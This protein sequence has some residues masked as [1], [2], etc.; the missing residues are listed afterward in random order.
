M[1]GFGETPDFFLAGVEI[2]FERVELFAG[3]MRF[4]HAEVRMQRLVA[5]RFACLPL[6]RTDLTLYLF[7]DVADAQ[8]IRFCS[9]QFAQRFA[10]LRFVF[11][12]SGR[13]LKNCAP[14]FRPRA[15]DH[16][17]L[18]LLHHRVS[19]TRDAGVCEKALNVTKAAG[20]FI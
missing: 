15:Q 17:D 8:Q 5:P 20:R 12:D 11:C 7:D 16:V 1:L 9:F 19:R 3:I 6:Q 14:I 18:A 4:K 2:S 13:F 10:L